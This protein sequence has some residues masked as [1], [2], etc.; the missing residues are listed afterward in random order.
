MQKNELTWE[1][2]PQGWALC[3]N[4]ECPLRQSCLR[5]QAG[6]LAPQELTV[7]RCITPSALANGACPH[8]ASAAPIQYARGFSTIYDNVL[9][10]D[11]TPLRK[12][13]TL[14]LSGKRY[15]YEYMRGE[16]RLSPAQ[17]EDIRE[18][19]TSWGYADSVH[20]DAFEQDFDFSWA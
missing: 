20:F 5:W 7:T 3:F 18:L 12:Q 19:F 1:K 17:Q 6:Q 10:R 8:F 2:V 4:T 13:M 9:K 15:Y 14:M 11:Y 16:R